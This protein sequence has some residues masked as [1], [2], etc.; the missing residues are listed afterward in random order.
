[1]KF[2]FFFFLEVGFWIWVKVSEKNPFST[3]KRGHYCT[4]LFNT[5]LPDPLYCL[6]YYFQYCAIYFPRDPLYCSKIILIL[7]ISCK[8]HYARCTCTRH[9]Q[10]NDQQSHY[11]YILNTHMYALYAVCV[12]CMVHNICIHTYQM[13]RSL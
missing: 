11:D 13:M 2:F 7:T 3:R 5:P 1:L 9:R 10:R 4:L 6:Q 8:G 12:V